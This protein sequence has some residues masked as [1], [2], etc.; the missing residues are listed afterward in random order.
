[1]NAVI[2]WILKVYIPEVSSWSF[3][4]TGSAFFLKLR[5]L[6]FS[7][8]TMD[9]IML[10]PTEQGWKSFTAGWAPDMPKAGTLTCSYSPGSSW[11]EEQLP[12]LKGLI[13]ARLWIEQACWLGT[14]GIALTPPRDTIILA[15]VR[16]EL[17]GRLPPDPLQ[18]SPRA[19]S[20]SDKRLLEEH[21]LSHLFVF[22]MSHWHPL[23]LLS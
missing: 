20:R 8:L 5:L 6:L 15:R 7:V 1:M 22:L 16:W 13:Y 17:G 3:G 23:L 2:S 10:L 12:S 19:L 9:P 14:S 21:I 11:G 18:S 4:E